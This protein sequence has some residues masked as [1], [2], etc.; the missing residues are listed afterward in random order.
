MTRPDFRLPEGV[1]YV[2]DEGDKIVMR[3]EIP[4]DDDGFFGRQCPACDQVFRVF[5]EDYEAL[6]D[7]CVFGVCTAATTMTTASSSRRSRRI[8]SCG[9]R[10]HR[11]QLVG[12]MLEE[13]FGG[14]AR[15][16]RGSAISFSYRSTPY[17]PEP[18]PGIDEVRLVRERSCSQCSLRYAVF[19]DHRFCPVC[20]PLAPGVVATDALAADTARLDV[21]RSLPPESVATLREQGVFDRIYVDT[22]ENL[23]S[24]VESLAS[25]VFRSS[26]SGAESIL[27]GKGNVFQRL[28]D[29]ADLYLTHLACDL[30]AVVG[31]PVWSLLESTWAARHVFGHNDGIVDTR[32]L[33][34]VPTATVS[35]GSGSRSPRRRLDCPSTLRRPCVTPLRAPLR[36]SCPPRPR[37]ES[38]GL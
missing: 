13:S 14:L 24:V 11:E 22:I 36:N 27:R 38:D 7:N 10:R 34:R 3:V 29:T 31:T 32:Y 37:P 9:R 19:G 21:L 30:R 2:G 20:G 18:L 26:V 1:E 17:Y 15:R 8:G 23:V 5:H 16:T 35:I 4:L 12:Q 33:A 6:P 25:S 28:D